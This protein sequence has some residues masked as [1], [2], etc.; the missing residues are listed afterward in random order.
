M[1]YESCLTK[2]CSSSKKLA[3][4]MLVEEIKS[5]LKEKHNFEKRVLPILIAVLLLFECQESDATERKK[6]SLGW[7]DPPKVHCLRLKP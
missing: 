6:I 2:Y 4:A 7:N 3:P 1:E 5:A